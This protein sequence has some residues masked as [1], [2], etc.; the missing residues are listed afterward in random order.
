M[1][2][3]ITNDDGIASPLLPPLVNAFAKI[4]SVTVVAPSTEQS[5]IGKGMSRFKDVQLEERTD[6]E[7]PTYALTGTP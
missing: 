2:T 6:F 5:W 4:G 7:H 3:L 1:H